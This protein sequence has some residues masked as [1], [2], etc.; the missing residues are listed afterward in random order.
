MV[1]IQWEN[2]FITQ[3]IDLFL[4][5]KLFLKFPNKKNMEKS[6]MDRCTENSL[7]KKSY[8]WDSTERALKITGPIQIELPPFRFNELNDSIYNA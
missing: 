1:L 6:L 7:I 2:F 8:S 5:A 3:W 4:V